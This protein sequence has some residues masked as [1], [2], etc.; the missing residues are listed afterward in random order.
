MTIV[1]WLLVPC[2]LAGAIIIGLLLASLIESALSIWYEYTASIIIPTIGLYSV[3]VIS[4]KIKLLVALF[5]SILGLGI[6]FRF[7]CPSWYPEW[8]AT[9]YQETYIPFII[10]C[11]TT[12]IH[13]FV[14]KY[15][16]VGELLN[17]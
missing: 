16:K 1:R 12:A 9:P 5:S 4:P 8:H 3:Y 17:T 13:M 10:V 14:L 7:A 11:I 15:S 2:V 6:A